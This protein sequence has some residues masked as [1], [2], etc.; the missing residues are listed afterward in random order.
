MIDK[1]LLE[2]SGMNF[3]INNLELST[4]MGRKALL[5]LGFMTDKSAITA[6]LERLEEF[7]IFL[8]GDNVCT[9]LTRGLKKLRDIS[10]SVA[11]LG[12]SQ[13][14]DDIEFFEL[15][16]FAISVEELITLLEGV[17]EAFRLV[18]MDG[19]TKILDPEGYRIRSFYIYDAYSE[20][21]KTVRRK[22][23]L[24]ESVLEKGGDFP[25]NELNR[26][27]IREKELELEIRCDLSSKL[28]RFVGA[29]EK[30]LHTLAYIDLSIAK[31]CL[32]GALNLSKPVV[33][34][35]ELEYKGLF[36]PEMEHSLSLKG[37]EFQPIDIAFSSGVS[38]ITGANMSG[39][40][41]LLRTLCL[42]Q[43]M[44]QI[45][46][47]V[48]A[49]HALMTPVERV[50]IVSGD[51]QSVLKG[52]SS[53]A[54]EMLELNTACEIVEERRR[55]LLLFDEPA[56]N[57]N[58][59]EGAAIVRAIVD[60]FDGR[61]SFTVIST[62]YDGITGGREV[63]HFRSA[64]LKLKELTDEKNVS[65]E[66][67]SEHFDYSIVEVKDTE[68]VPREALAVAEILG[69]NKSVIAKARKFLEERGGT[70]D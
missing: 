26:L 27:H 14:L 58:P 57:T 5:D 63:K 4:P 3:I 8:S 52:L 13:V 20:E 9:E 1:D 64:G 42:T 30:N 7:F 70:F 44:F 25:E 16:D 65:P 68:E 46:F 23:R 60:Y 10:G 33:G 19:M 31:F 51:Y 35:G 69:V 54:A 32:A 24:A 62:H 40:T 28:L 41:V 22:R 39:K 17:P 53:F 43:I 36:N 61:D 2:R 45:G 48:P 38:V 55:G 34:E 18:S 56:R 50:V 66:D 15:K 47:Y 67:L 21:L 37:K 11:R 59:H 12:N 6:E 49:T 29:L